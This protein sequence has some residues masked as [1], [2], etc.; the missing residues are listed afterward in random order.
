[1]RRN[2]LRAIDFDAEPHVKQ[3]QVGNNDNQDQGIVLSLGHLLGP[4]QLQIRVRQW[5]KPWLVTSGS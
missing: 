4:R 2:R 1:M 3:Q 5:Q